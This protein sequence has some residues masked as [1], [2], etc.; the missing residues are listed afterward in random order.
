M[1]G[2]TDEECPVCGLSASRRIIDLDDDLRAFSCARCGDYRITGLAALDCRSASLSAWLREAS[3]SDRTPPVLRTETVKTVLAGLPDYSV[4]EKQ[5]L[6]LHALG[7]K[8]ALPGQDVGVDWQTDF[9]LAWAAAPSEFNYYL[10]SLEDRGLVKLSARATSGASVVVQ[11]RGW[12]LIG[13]R[14][15]PGFSSPQAFVAMSFSGD[16]LPL[17]TDGIKPAIEKAG[18]QAMRVDQDP[19][20][21]KIDAR[22]LNEIRASH[23]VVADCTQQRPSVYFEAGYALALG[24]PVIWAVRADELADVHFDTRQYPY[25]PWET[26]DHLGKELY[27]L[28]GAVIGFRS[29]PTG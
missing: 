14:L 7:R 12:D 23:F 28:I 25:I 5:I 9:P 6:L 1:A 27:D 18:Y 19:S 4:S 22:I 11:P 21:E 3:E 26:P 24:R 2:S 10:S 16:L 15:A 8:T 13:E 17:W 20:L 29:R